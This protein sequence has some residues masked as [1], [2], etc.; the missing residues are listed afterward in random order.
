[1]NKSLSTGLKM[2]AGCLLGLLLLSGQALGQ[3]F[4]FTINSQ[5]SGLAASL[6]FSATLPGSLIG[7]WD[8]V[9][10]P[11]G[12]RTKPGLFGTFGETENVAAAINIVAG[13]TGEE[14]DTEVAGTFQ[15]ELVDN[16]DGTYG[17][18]VRNYASN[19]ISNGDL[20][21]PVTANVTLPSFRTRNPSST[22]IAATL[23]IPLGDATFSVLS[24]TQDGEAAGTATPTVPGEFTLAVPMLVRYE[25]VADIFGNP[26]NTTTEPTPYLLTGTLTVSGSTA[27]ITS[28]QP[29][30]ITQS[31]SPDT[32]LPPLPFPLPTILPPGSTAN[33]ILNLT[34]S[35][36]TAG[37][38][39]TQTLVAGG[40]QAET[41]CVGDFNQDGGIDGSDVDAFFAAWSAGDASADVNQDGGIDG[42]DVDTFFIAW[43]SGSC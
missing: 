21:V 7:N 25:T 13:I 27:S 31:E 23:P 37:V 43:E 11:T 20:V 1:M 41:L 26:I 3:T 30:E 29:L 5:Q 35:Q 16:G 2:R 39:G 19:L 34:L 12:T 28:S 4:D 15:L 18:I 42:S 14:L 24:I 36:I 6:N 40:T 32:E 38:L 22:Y 33:V 9:E 8:A 10:N 17:V